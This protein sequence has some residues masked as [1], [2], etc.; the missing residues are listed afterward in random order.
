LVFSAVTGWWLG[1]SAFGGFL[2]AKGSMQGE[3][4]HEMIRETGTSG[5]QWLV[6]GKVESKSRTLN[7][8]RAG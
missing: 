8:H 1:R 7:Q 3:T 4:L 5:M 6:A 2:N